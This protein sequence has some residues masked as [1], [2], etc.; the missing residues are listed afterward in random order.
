MPLRTRQPAGRD[1]RSGSGGRAADRQQGAGSPDVIALRKVDAEPPHLVQ[2][3]L[4]LD[5]FR[6]RLD[7]Q[8]LGERDDALSE[9]PVL[10]V[11][12]NVPDE[13]TF[14]LDVID[15]ESLELTAAA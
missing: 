9:G 1:R 14:D 8:L 10:A 4:V 15:R 7:L 2:N 12:E 6:D 5:V 11:V 3:G 13:F